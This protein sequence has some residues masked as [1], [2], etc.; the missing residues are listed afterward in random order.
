MWAVILMRKYSKQ[1]MSTFFQNLI[2][3]FN[4]DWAIV[5]FIINKQ[6]N[7]INCLTISSMDHMLQNSLSYQVFTLRP[8]QEVLKYIVMQFLLKEH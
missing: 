8:E 2:E 1:N 7:K 4:T 5:Y 3:E 6:T